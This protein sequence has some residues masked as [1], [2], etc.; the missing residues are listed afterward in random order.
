MTVTVG[1][2]APGASV[3]PAALD[4][5]PLEP[6]PPVPMW[7]E[8]YAFMIN[9]PGDGLALASQLG[10]W[11]VDPS[12]W[13]EFFMLALPGER[14]VYHKAFGRE[15]N[16]QQIRASL[17]AIDVLEPGQ[18]YRLRFDGPV[19]SDRR[20]SLLTRG[21]T[22][23]PLSPLQFDLVFE[24]VAPPWDMSGHAKA[25]EALA[26]KLHVEQVGSVSGV[27][28]FGEESY[29]IQGAFGQR[30]HSRGIRVITQLHR[31]CWAQGWF[32]EAELTFNLYM[33]AVHGGPPAMSNASLATKGRRL[34][35]KVVSIDLMQAAGD[36]QRAYAVTIDS[37]LGP[38]TFEIDR[39]VASM[40]AAF[41]SPYDK[42]PGAMPGFHA[43][44][45]NEEA[46][47]WKWNGLEGPGWSERS[48]N[49]S[50][51]PV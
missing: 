9:S 46:V 29:G 3:L 23:R 40:P 22:P 42:S 18:A 11:P 39:F 35:A 28:T 47:V 44:S 10:R 5:F 30:D 21:I 17:F 7:S 49:A 16:L 43:A 33:M 4:D 25:A 48:F 1:N 6:F 34:D 15:P 50:P 12:V 14:I 24:G 8:N 37:E 13:R 31:H 51:F 32:P 36:H 27:V 26:G 38:M 2:S 41:C 19:S 20:D 45:S